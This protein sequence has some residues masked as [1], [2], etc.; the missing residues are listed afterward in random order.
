MNSWDWPFSQ[1]YASLGQ[2][3][4]QLVAPSKVKAPSLLKVN[5]ALQSELAIAASDED[6][7]GVLSG[8]VVP[9][10]ARPVAS[11][12]AGHQFGQFSARL[13]DGRAILLGELNCLRGVQ[14]IQLKG[15]GITPFSRGGDGRAA[16]GPALR[17]YLMSEA[18][19]ALGVPTTRALAVVA[20]GQP[21]YR[22]TPLPGAIVTRV[23]SSHVRVGTFEYFARTGQ[24]AQVKVLADF[25]IE[26]HYPQLKNEPYPYAA[27]LQ[28][29]ARRQSELV[30]KWMQI[31]FVHGVMNTDNTAVSGETIDYGPCAFLDAYAPDK[32]FSYIDQGGRYAYGRQSDIVVWN[33][34]RLA[35]C[36]LPLIDSDDQK[37]VTGAQEI[38]TR[39]HEAIQN[40][41]AAAFAAKIGLQEEAAGAELA[42]SLLAIMDRAGA[43]FTLCFRRLALGLKERDFNQWQELFNG[44]ADER[45]AA[46]GWLAKWRY[47]LMSKNDSE[48][49]IAEQMLR[50]NPAIIP[51]NHRVEEALAEAHDIVL[52]GA[53]P[54]PDMPKFDAL[55]AALQT[56][57]DEAWDDT[58]LADAT[59][60]NSDGYTTFCGT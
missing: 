2:D 8:N 43:D 58:P 48:T 24:Q 40:K 46:A 30:V 39:T 51:R 52:A 50:L 37:A 35:E 29:I 20:T 10:H 7:V 38:L 55:F 12:Y 1:H 26:R 49:V 60:A 41:L 34:S 5:R 15:A 32:R 53:Q 45:K 59:Q 18:M 4:A 42:Q 22:E 6:L 27:L 3:F 28:S 23:A 21:V 11:V 33:L 25:V 54:L 47:A 14:E 13:G 44:I 17:E 56:P 19:H 57:F 9:E 36:L 16:L 31:G